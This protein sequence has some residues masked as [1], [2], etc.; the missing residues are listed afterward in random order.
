MAEK[1]RSIRVAAEFREIDAY[2]Y[3]ESILDEFKTLYRFMRLTLHN[4]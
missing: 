4:I 3:V 1:F 2:Y